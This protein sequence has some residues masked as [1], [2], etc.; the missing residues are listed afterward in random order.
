MPK[1]EILRDPI[2]F[3]WLF[4]QASV[5]RDKG[6]PETE[7]QS[8]QQAGPH[9]SPRISSEE[10]FDLREAVVEA[11]DSLEPLELWLI[12]AL[13]FERLSLRD[14]EYVLGI[15]KTTVARKRDKI[16][17]KLRLMLEDNPYVREHIYGETT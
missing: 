8:L 14:V 10:R 7:I 5:R 15:P 2:E 6:Q 16:L 17:A 12:N 13:L 4:D 1:R 11:I 3:A 9:Q